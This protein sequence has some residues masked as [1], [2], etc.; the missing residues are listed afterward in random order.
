MRGACAPTSTSA[1][2]PRRRHAGGKEAIEEIR[3]LW[4][5]LDTPDARAALQ[6]LP[7]RARDRDRIGNRRA[8]ARLLAARSA[9]QHRGRGDRE[10]PARRDRRG[11]PQRGHQRRDDPAPARHL[12]PQDDA[13]GTGRARAPH[14]AR[15]TFAM[16]PTASRPTPPSHRRRHPGAGAEAHTRPRRAIRCATGPRALRQRAHRPNGRAARA[17]SAARFTRTAPRAFTSTSTPRTAGSASAVSATATPSTTSHPRSGACRHAAA[18]SSS[19]APASTRCSCQ[20]RAPHG[21]GGGAEMPGNRRCVANACGRGAITRLAEWLGVCACAEGAR[22]VAPTA[23]GTST[24]SRSRPGARTTGSGEIGRALQRPLDIPLVDGHDADQ[25]H[26]DHHDNHH[27]KEAAGDRH[28][29]PRPTTGAP[30]T[31]ARSCSTA[32]ATPTSS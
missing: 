28:R 30:T 26:T 4:V 29:Q 24:N 3:T 10:P 7:G 14:R 1:S 15:T 5:D 22:Q 18:S 19:S 9:R 21:E 12:L 16:S 17:R 31:A 25:V 8:P 2:P 6:G 11:P 20:E 23:H 27:R 32:A 13:A